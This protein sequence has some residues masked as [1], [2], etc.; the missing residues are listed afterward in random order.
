MKLNDIVADEKH[1]NG[2]L[3]LLIFLLVVGVT[4]GSV[5]LAKNSGDMAEGIKNYI[6]SFCTAVSEN[7]NSMTVFKNSLQANLISVGIVFLMGFLR[8]GFIVT[9]AIIVRK[10]FIIG[11][12][13]A[14]FIKFYGAKGMLVMLSTMPTILITIP[15]LLLF[16]A[17]SIK[18]SLNSER[19]SKKWPGSFLSPAISYIFFMI[20]IIS[21]FC[22]ASLSEG[23]LTT[24]FMSW[25]SPKLN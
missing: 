23:Y 22:V 12:T 2:L 9:G 11:F 13:T 10:G 4:V 16:S 21:I 14:S 6:G 15:T 3:G 8:F 1:G 19:K 25:V 18:Y 5:Y 20:I 17:V 24:T 7:K